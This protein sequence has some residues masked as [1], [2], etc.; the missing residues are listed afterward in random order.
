MVQT[1]RSQWVLAGE[2]TIVFEK[3]LVLQ[4]IFLSVSVIVCN[5]NGYQIKLSFGDPLPYSFVTL[6][7]YDKHF[8]VRGAD[9]SQEDVWII[10]SSDALF[11]YSAI[12]IL[13]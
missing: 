4:R 12:Q 6:D 8:E 11:L 5:T 2:K 3:P 13:H 9:I 10:N 1:V 7:G